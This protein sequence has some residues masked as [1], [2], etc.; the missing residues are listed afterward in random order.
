MKIFKVNSKQT[1]FLTLSL[2]KQ[3]ISL[4]ILF[5]SKVRN[6]M[7]HP[8]LVTQ[9]MLQRQPNCTELRSMD[10]YIQILCRFQKCKQKVP[11]P[12]LLSNYYL[13]LSKLAFSS[14]FQFPMLMNQ[15]GISNDCMLSVQM[16]KEVGPQFYIQLVYTAPLL[17]TLKI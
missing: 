6:N 11:P 17:I 4:M 10:S 5:I 3:Y 13:Y 7:K 14:Q 2:G 9:P 8:T 1:R 15:N 16:S 12:S